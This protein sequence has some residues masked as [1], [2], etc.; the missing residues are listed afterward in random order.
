MYLKYKIQ[1]TTNTKCSCS[2]G[3]LRGWCVTWSFLRA[4]L[5]R[6]IGPGWTLHHGQDEEDEHEGDEHE[7]DG[8]DE[9]DDEDDDEDEYEI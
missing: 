1:S 7:D 8:E 3:V 9:D 4:A 2:D 6:W 5:A